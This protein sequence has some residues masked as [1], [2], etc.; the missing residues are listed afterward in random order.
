MSDAGMM[1][2][3]CGAHVQG[4]RSGV[5]SD[6]HPGVHPSVLA[7]GLT[8][9]PASVHSGSH[10]GVRFD[11]HPDRTCR[12]GLTGAQINIIGLLLEIGPT[13]TPYKRLALELERHYAM[14][15]S[16]EAV[17]RT[18]ERLA[19][20]GFLRRKKA[21]E[22]TMQGVIF[23]LVYEMLCPHIRPPG[24]G[25]HPDVHSGVRSGVRSDSFSAP[26]ILEKKDREILSISSQST[27]GYREK[28]EALDEEDVAFHWPELARAGFGTAQ[29]RQIIQRR[30]QVAED[31]R[32]V[33]QGLT[34]AEWEL[35]RQCMKDAKG[36]AVEAPVNWVFRI[37]ASQGYYPRPPGYISPDEQAERDREEIIKREQEAREA[38]F[39]VEAEAWAAALSVDEREAILGPK[40]GATAIMPEVVRLRMHFKA[41]IWPQL[42]KTEKERA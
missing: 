16:P 30:E 21:K 8:C 41:E 25:V 38:R 15:R 3:P 13:V 20:R 23:H 35:A 28:L 26:S 1:A 37:L 22:G 19:G 27:Q 39:A 10:S 6:V 2:A 5:L 11:V 33:M 12:K 42:S 4:V 29:I 31:A 34:F 40:D 18:V 14:R 17:R 9:V 24:Q 7:C 36:N 32:H